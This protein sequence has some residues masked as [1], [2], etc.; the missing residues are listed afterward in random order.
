[1]DVGVSPRHQFAIVPDDTIDFIERNSHGLSPGIDALAA[2]LAPW[3][4]LMGLDL[5]GASSGHAFAECRS[6][7]CLAKCHS[8]FATSSTSQPLLPSLAFS[9]CPKRC[10]GRKRLKVSSWLAVL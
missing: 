4:R 9:G 5:A 10:H 2:R 3:R 8:T 7:V 1:M 6:P